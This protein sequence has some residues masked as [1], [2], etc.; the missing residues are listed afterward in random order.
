MKPLTIRLLILLF[1]NLP[2]LSQ[3]SAMKPKPGQVSTTCYFNNGPKTGE[4]EILKGHKPVAIGKP[5]SDDAGNTGIAVFDKQDE[6]AEEAEEAELEAK[7][8]AKG[9][10]PGSHKILSTL[11]QFQLGPKNGQQE[12]LSDKT[13]ALPI[14]SPCSDGVR[15]S[16]RIIAEPTAQQ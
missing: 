1:F 2:H 8:I 14:G 11:C 5:C 13:T 6:E 12:N 4:S 7:R 15:S 3:A 10:K 16:G 9:L